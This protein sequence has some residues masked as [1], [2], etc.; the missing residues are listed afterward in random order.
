M[1]AGYKRIRYYKGAKDPLG[2]VQM[3]CQDWRLVECTGGDP[4][5]RFY[6][7]RYGDGSFTWERGDPPAPCGV[8]CWPDWTPIRFETPGGR[9]LP[10][11]RAKAEDVNG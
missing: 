9:S 5:D 7:V 6:G 3:V 1:A 4:D 8:Y 11:L 10:N 2:C